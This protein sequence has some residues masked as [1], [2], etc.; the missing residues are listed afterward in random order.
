MMD[1]VRELKVR[2][3]LLHKR[4]ASN[5]AAA[6]QRLRALP[7]LGRADEAALAAAAPGIRRKHCLAVVAREC[8]FS[9]WERAPRPRG[10]ARRARARDVALRRG[11]RRAAPLVRDPRRGARPRRVAAGGAAQLPAHVQTSLLRRRPHVRRVARARPRR[12]GLAGDWM[13]LGAAR[14]PDRATPALREAAR[15]DAGIGRSASG[16]R[17]TASLLEAGGREA[18]LAEEVVEVRPVAAG[19]L[20]GGAD[21]AAGAAEHLD[22]VGALE[23][24]ARRLERGELRAGVAE[25]DRHG[26]ARGVGGR[27]GLGLLGR[28]G[29]RPAVQLA[30]GR[31]EQGAEL[32]RLQARAAREQDG[33]F[34]DVRELPDVAG[35]GVREQHAQ[36][37]GGELGA[38]EAVAGRG[39]G[40]E[41]LAEEGDVLHALAER[42]HDDGHDVEAIEEI[43]AEAA[44]ADLGA[45]VAVGRGDDAD[46]D[47]F[48]VQGADAGDAPLLEHAEE[49]HLDGGG[50]VADLVEEEGAAVRGGEQARL[51]ARGA[52]E[53]AAHVAEQLALQELGRQGAAVDGD[54]GP[55]APLGE[56]VERAR[57][58]L[59]AG[60][61]LAEQEDG[62]VG[63]RDAGDDLADGGDAVARAEQ[64]QL[65]ALGADDAAEA[66]DL[67]AQPAAL[68]G[69]LDLLEQVEV[70]EGLRE[71]AV[72]AA[73][74][75]LDGGL[76]RAVGREDDD[77]HVRGALLHLA[78]HVEPVAVVE[79]EVDD[80]G[81]H[82]LAGEG[83]DA[84]A[85]GQLRGDPVAVVLEAEGEQLAEV[86]LVVDDDHMGLPGG[87]HER[88]AAGC[89]AAGASSEARSV[90]SGTQRR[91]VA[92]LAR[93]PPPRAAP[94]SPA[95]AAAPSA[96]PR[97][98]A[99]AACSS[100]SRSPPWARAILRERARPRPMPTRLGEFA[101]GCVLNSS[102][103][104]CRISAGTPGP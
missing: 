2:A 47:V 17:R 51:V 63:G 56:V 55:A 90:E 8:G 4:V 35:P 77:G 98:S 52:G 75:R 76:D 12:P 71:E 62:G 65:V 102:K 22:E 6:L 18:V 85:A 70:V 9:S 7:E 15:R 26:L 29:A 66:G 73:P 72:G 10:R 20:R 5:D 32:L 84:A 31:D 69:V 30:G 3:E 81:V 94:P 54:E 48:L 79:A 92:P 46:V 86:R 67:A 64:A 58:Q 45:E 97:A 14:R 19:E 83:G 37:L 93:S 39:A 1:P 68:D 42:G 53:G 61:G 89:S 59:L 99:R 28:G 101:T 74:H 103:R 57:R 23:E 104:D 60:A 95:E 24:I 13:G 21:V 44:V 49:L 82:G 78:E 91:K 50:S 100:S 96:E 80:H 40:E 16:P 34:H 33:A 88:A 27:G 11:R 87:A 25:D 36:R 43:L 38:G 41:D